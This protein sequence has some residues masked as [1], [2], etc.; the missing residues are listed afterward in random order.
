MTAESD[1]TLD[2]DH[3]P[4]REVIARKET[5]RRYRKTDAEYAQQWGITGKHVTKKL[6]RMKALGRMVEPH[7]MPPFDE[8]RLLAEW[9]RRMREAGLVK[10]KVPDWM[11]ELE[12]GAEAEKH[13]PEVPPAEV[14][15]DRPPQFVLPVVDGDASPGERQLL[16]F[17]AGWLKEM[18]SAQRA[19][20]NRRFLKAWTEYKALLKELRSW[21]KDRQRER[22]T[23]GEVMEAAKE[24]EVLAAIFSTMAKTFTGALLNLTQSLKPEMDEIQRRRLVLP[25]RDRIFSGL[26]STRFMKALPDEMMASYAAEAKAA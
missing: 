9:W 4:A 19:M 11:E 20:D 16:E 25:Y 2:V 14:N 6:K 12:T 3:V 22:L 24:K 13:P 1:L 8:P 26:K 10:R 21:Q 5:L 18:N 15:G 17:A 7:D 23:T